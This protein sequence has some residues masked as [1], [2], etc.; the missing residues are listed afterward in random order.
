MSHNRKEMIS[1]YL[2]TRCN[3]DCIYCY[4]NKNA[5]V[6]AHQ[7]LNLEFAKAGIDDYYKTG[8]AHHVRFFSAGEPTVEFGMMKEIHTYALEKD[9]K[10]TFE[11]QTNGCFSERIAEWIA[12]NIDIIWIS[13][14]GLPRVQDYCRPFIGGG[15]TSDILEKNIRYLTKNCRKMVGIRMTIN[16]FNV[17]GQLDIVRYFA[18]LGI[19]NFWADP[20]FPEI[21]STE[22]MESAD[23]DVFVKE[24]TKAVRYAY[25]NGMTYGS[26]LT[27]NFDEPGEYA[28]RACL[29][30][31]HLTTDG[32]VSACDMALFGNDSDHM[33]VFIYGRWN[34]E[35]HFIE[36]DQEKI[37][38]LRARK[39]SNMPACKGC[40]IGEYC[41]GYCL[42]EVM[43]ET[44]NLFG[45]KQKI[46]EPSRKLFHILTEKEKKYKY[47]HP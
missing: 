43:N 39:L 47:Y 10:T 37:E 14:D 13:S 42:G 35:G 5:G 32:Y 36:Y 33:S 3:L 29:P 11:I 16:N 40:E 7:T 9:E 19:K 26:I 25:D 24:F 27:C 45:C 23:M 6:H 38:R 4:T 22:A 21:G 12:E 28:C 34:S 17:C 31:P 15:K 1:F 20:V 46:C 2:T 44:R 18:E 30:V 8:F 41:R